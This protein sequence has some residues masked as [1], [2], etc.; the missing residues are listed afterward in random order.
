MAV[1]SIT[2]IP[3]QCFELQ[4]LPLEKVLSDGGKWFPFRR[5]NGSLLD[6]L[7]YSYSSLSLDG[8]RHFDH[9]FSF[10]FNRAS[11]FVHIL[12]KSFEEA[13]NDKRKRDSSRAGA[14]N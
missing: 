5:H 1:S 12:I 13:Q 9:G 8:G 2:E 6:C 14:A 3:Y 4:L 7:P 11:C 10:S